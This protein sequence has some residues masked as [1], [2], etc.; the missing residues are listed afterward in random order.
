[1]RTNGANVN[2]LDADRV[3]NNG[4]IIIEKSTPT[5]VRR[6]CS[7]GERDLHTL[8]HYVCTVVAYQVV[9]TLGVEFGRPQENHQIFV[10]VFVLQRVFLCGTTIR[11]IS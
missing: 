6:P 11:N 4:K 3:K 7:Y 8:I 10:G 5:S 2:R 1:M 9:R